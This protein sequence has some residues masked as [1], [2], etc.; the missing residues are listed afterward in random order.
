MLGHSP[1]P[2]PARVFDFES[3]QQFM[4]SQWPLYGAPGGFDRDRQML[5]EYRSRLP[6][7]LLAR[8]PFCG[9]PVAE[10]VDTF[11]LNGF[12]WRDPNCGLG[13]ATNMGVVRK[14]FNY[15][16]HVKIISYFLNLQG[17]VPDDLFPGKQ[18]QSGPELPS[19]MNVP[20]R[21]EGTAVVMHRLAVGRFDDSTPQRRYSLY[22]LSYFA[23]QPEAFNAAID[24]WDIHY[25]MAEYHDVDYDLSSWA[26]RKRLLWLDPNSP[27]LPLASAES[28]QFPYGGIQGDRFPYRTLTR[29]GVKLPQPGLFERLLNLFSRRRG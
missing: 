10:P 7:H 18:I 9:N 6:V 29:E 8:C 14:E 2:Q 3:Y 26:V 17:L 13:W 1:L 28:A 22:F 27:E 19:I 24:G 16:D 4:R 15:C 25:G 12:G 5:A 21:A 20:M 11:S 23:S